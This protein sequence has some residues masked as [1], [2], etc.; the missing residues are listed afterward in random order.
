MDNEI[1]NELKERLGGQ[2]I[3]LDIGFGAG[4]ISFD[5]LG[6][7]TIGKIRGIES[8]KKEEIETDHLTFLGPENDKGVYGLIKSDNTIDLFDYYKYRVGE[9]KSMDLESFNEKV[10]FSFS[11]TFKEFIKEN[12]DRFD[13]AVLFNVLHYTDIGEPEWV[14]DQVKG[15]LTENGLILISFKNFKQSVG[16]IDEDRQE[17]NT[18][19][20]IEL[21]ETDFKTIIC[22]D[23]KTESS[24]IYL[25]ERI[26]P[27]QNIFEFNGAVAE[28]FGKFLK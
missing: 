8:R 23:S 12:N 5:I 2:S 21:L 26:R 4:R 14:L 10:D 19:S 11:K 15:I 3:V 28:V 18:P 13:L 24:I 20:M 6:E 9:N 1:I 7:L 17:I 16:Q 27:Q 25:G 22:K